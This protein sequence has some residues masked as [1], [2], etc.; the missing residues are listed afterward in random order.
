MKVSHL[1]FTLIQ[2]AKQDDLSHVNFEKDIKNQILMKCLSL[3]SSTQQIHCYQY[4]NLLMCTCD[5]SLLSTR[6]EVLFKPSVNSVI[7]TRN[8]WARAGELSKHSYNNNS[9]MIAWN[10]YNLLANCTQN[11]L[12][13]AQ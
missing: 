12:C 1:P 9:L 13:V 2:A 8:L 7:S 5:T 10:L 11:R 4:H 6:C 3:Q